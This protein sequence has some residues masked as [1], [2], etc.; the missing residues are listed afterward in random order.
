MGQY[1]YVSTVF[2]L[3]KFPFFTTWSP[4]LHYTFFVRNTVRDRFRVIFFYFHCFDNNSSIFKAQKRVKGESNPPT[5]YY[6]YGVI[7]VSLS[8]PHYLNFQYRTHWHLWEQLLLFII[9][10]ISF[11]HKI[12]YGTVSYRTMFL[13]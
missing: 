6:R 1:E 5:P 11:S 13:N 8:T 4:L 7:R 9:Y 12:P 2:G 3:W 10:S